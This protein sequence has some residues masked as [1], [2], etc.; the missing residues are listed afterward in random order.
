MTKHITITT[1]RK[2][3]IGIQISPVATRSEIIEI[4][5]AVE[6]FLEDA[7][8]LRAAITKLN[9]SLPVKPVAADAYLDDVI[10]GGLDLLS[11]IEARP[12]MILESREWDR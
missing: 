3:P 6:R 5:L 11:E 7:R 2:S 4:G 9:C 12:D 10:H 8:E 1:D